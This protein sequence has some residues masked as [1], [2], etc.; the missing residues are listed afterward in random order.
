MDGRKLWNRVIIPNGLD[1]LEPLDSVI[2]VTTNT[3]V[4]DVSDIL[5]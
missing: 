2:I 1:T 5:E 3:S 4:K